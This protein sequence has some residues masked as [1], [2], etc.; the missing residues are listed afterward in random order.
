MS[1][2]EYIRY[3]RRCDYE[4][5]GCTP[6]LVFLCLLVVLMLTACKETEY[7]PVV[8]RHEVYHHHTDTVRQTDSIL[9]E[10]TTVIR[11]V[12]SATMAQYGIELRKAERAWLVLQKDMERRIH[13]LMQAKSD[14]IIIRDTIQV[15]VP[16]ERK[17]TKWELVKLDMGGW[18]VG[19]IIISIIGFCVYLARRNVSRRIQSS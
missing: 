15:P 4:R 12:D 13:E 16:V 8:E 11:E 3:A 19:I 14:T 17:L 18:M 1:W 7:V 9:S 2:K 6:P 10:K 5:V